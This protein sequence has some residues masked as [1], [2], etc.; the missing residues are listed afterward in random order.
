MSVKSTLST[1]VSQLLD[2]CRSELKRD[3][4]RL[5]PKERLRITAWECGLQVGHKPIT[6]GSIFDLPRRPLRPCSD[7]DFKN[8]LLS[9]NGLD[10]DEIDRKC[11]RS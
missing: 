1:V 9:I 8:S 7:E 10:P 11:W 5:L 4:V 2:L 6:E 3:P